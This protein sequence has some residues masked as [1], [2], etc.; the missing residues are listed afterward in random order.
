MLER[1]DPSRI[2]LSEDRL[3][4]VSEWLEQQIESQRLAG[5]S[6]LIARHGDVG[7]FRAAGFAD[8][9]QSKP[10]NEDTLV[11]IFS[12]TK[13]ITSVAAMM[14]YEQGR[15]QL[16][17][18][19]AKYLP[20]F[21][22][23]QVWK[24][25]NHPLEAVE[26]QQ[27]PML[28]KHLFTH[29]SG[30]TYGFMNTNVVDAQYRAQG[31]EFPGKPDDLAQWVEQLATVP[32]MCQPGSQWNYSVATDVLG[33]L[34]EVW[35]GQSLAEFFQDRIFTPL[36]MHDSGFAVAA[37]N[38]QRFAALYSP[39][40][41]GDMSS[42][43]SKS[44]P[45]PDQPRGGLKLMESSTKSAYFEHPKLCSGGGGL[46]GSIGDYAKFCQMLLN[47]GELNGERLLS[48]TTVNYMRLNQLPDGQDMAAMGQPVWS[49]TS[50]D[51]IGFGLGFA[52]VIDP[53]K[54]SVITSKGEH[55]WGGAAST[56][57]WI[58]PTED[59]FV[60]FFTQLMPSSTYPIR[61]ELRA[62]V[63]QAIVE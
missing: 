30:L 26:P 39:L 11:R 2:G 10:F 51:G 42:V 49:E 45:T 14:L 61:R 53:P 3:E 54:A 33:R 19:V 1:V 21:A 44:S 29:T 34:V 13:P 57:F 43:G 8:V 5:A 17:D 4:R 50:Y 46:T 40:S 16:D 7:Y 62:R 47:G 12:M 60:V 63:Y 36:G 58:D 15:F 52:V 48:P 37:E 35:S 27:N 9:E 56:F 6:V 25:G 22:Q 23:T 55:H 31:L 32:L 38:Q 18:P 20:E 24:G 59:L 41:G 28:I